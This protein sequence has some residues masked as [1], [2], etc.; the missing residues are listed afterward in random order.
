MYSHKI[1]NFSKQV[2]CGTAISLILKNVPI[3]VSQT[4]RTQT[5]PPLYSL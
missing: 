3:A 4:E 2:K 5:F 1:P